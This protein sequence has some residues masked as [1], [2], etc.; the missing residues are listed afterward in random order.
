MF[1]RCF[2][3]FRSDGGNF[4]FPRAADE[5]RMFIWGKTHTCNCNNVIHLVMYTKSGQKSSCCNHAWSQRTTSTD[6]ST[7]AFDV[8]QCAEKKGFMLTYSD[9]L[10]MFVL[11]YS[12]FTLYNVHCGA[13]VCFTIKID[14]H[15]VT[16][17][18]PG[19]H[20]IQCITFPVAGSFPHPPCH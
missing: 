2:L 1:M 13:S 5:K 9:F 15:H 10:V 18:G 12:T 11:A 19:G 7:F 14:K 17:I 20:S 3:L 4:L 16:S 8:C 6:C